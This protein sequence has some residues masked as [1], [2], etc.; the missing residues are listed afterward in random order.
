MPPLNKKKVKS[1]DA[2]GVDPEKDWVDL[3]DSLKQFRDS[4]HAA[5]ERPAFFWKTQ[6][7][8]IMARVSQPQ[9]VRRMW[10]WV[11]ATMAI[12][13]CLFFFV[14]NSK[15]PTPDIAAGSDQ[16]L[17]IDIERALD[18]DCPD[19]LAPAS[20]LGGEIDRALNSRESK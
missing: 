8:A 1:I 2:Q 5:A 4:I 6:Q 17:L 14:E 11:P 19:A 15:A 13:M 16:N 3:E 10:V 20:L 18:Q 9:P 7:N 12:L